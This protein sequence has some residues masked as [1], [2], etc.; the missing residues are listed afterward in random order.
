MQDADGFRVLNFE[1]ARKAV[2]AKADE[3][4][5]DEKA[6]AAGPVVTV[7]TAV[8]TYAAA[9]NAREAA[10]GRVRR[11]ADNR[12][13][14]H[15]LSDHLADVGL[16]Q[17]TE[18]D[19][20]DWR[21]RRSEGARSRPCA[22][23]RTICERRSMPPR[24]STGQ[25]FPAD[26]PTVIKA[27]LASES[28]DQPIAR[29]GAALADEDVRRLLDA[30][31]EIDE[32][33]GWDGDLH[34]LVV[35]LAATGARF[36]QVIRVRVGDV[37][38]DKGRL[39]V[40]VSRKGRGGKNSSHIVVRIGEDV[41]GVLVPATMGRKSSEPLLTRWLKEQRRQGF[42]PMEADRDGPRG[43]PLPRSGGRGWRS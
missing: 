35:T 13:A 38:A 43:R 42:C 23:S 36:S 32:E 7:G 29:D 24:R 20:S 27:G 3:W 39:M 15:V 28:H 14:W 8:K 25:R 9:M 16:H 11:D 41:I 21:T 4:R 31:G 2:L 18:T 22:V 26:L 10:Q 30:A 6:K 37:Q 5:S 12:L 34:R 33:H 1:Q 40:P 17:L 19:L